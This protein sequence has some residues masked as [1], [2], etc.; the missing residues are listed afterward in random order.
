MT[1]R[2]ID[3]VK[4]VIVTSSVQQI[5][6]ADLQGRQH[7]YTCKQQVTTFYTSKTIPA[8]TLYF[9]RTKSLRIGIASQHF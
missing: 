8:N 9:K 1:E 7:W 2:V 5:Q 4:P 3:R 6:T